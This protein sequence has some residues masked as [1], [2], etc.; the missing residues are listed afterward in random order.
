MGEQ[1]SERIG[2]ERQSGSVINP[3]IIATSAIDLSRYLV[4]RFPDDGSSTT[5]AVNLVRLYD[6]D[7]IYRKIPFVSFFL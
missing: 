4:G 7:R 2:Q 6:S 1:A 3:K 5:G